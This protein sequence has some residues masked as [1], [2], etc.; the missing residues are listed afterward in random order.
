MREYRG[1]RSTGFGVV[2]K[3]VVYFPFKLTMRLKEIDLRE[4]SSTSQED[5]ENGNRSSSENPHVVPVVHLVILAT[6]IK[7]CF[8]SMTSPSFY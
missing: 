4:C 5:K 8:Q 6:K 3:A 1:L 7:S 2:D